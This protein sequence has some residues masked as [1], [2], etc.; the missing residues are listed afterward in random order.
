MVFL[1]QNGMKSGTIR[2]YVSAL[3]A[4][5]AQY[6]ETCLGPKYQRCITVWEKECGSKPTHAFDIVDDLAKLYSACWSMSYWGEER[7]L[8]CWT[9]FLVSICMFARASEVTRFCPVFEDMVLPAASIWDRDGYPP[10]IYV[11]LRNWKKRSDLNRGKPYKMKIW[12]NYMKACYCPVFS[13]LK[14]LHYS[15][16]SSG[17]IFQLSHKEGKKPKQPKK[18]FWRA[19]SEGQW[20]GMTTRLFIKVTEECFEGHICYSL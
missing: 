4:L 2:V 10:F 3:N 9:M 18:I 20:T 19:L 1:K 14:W 16:I 6:G 12:R 11:V 13:L 15:G 5:C 8:L 17:P 7:K